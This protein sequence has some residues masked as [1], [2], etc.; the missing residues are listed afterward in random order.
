MVVVIRAAP[1]VDAQ[2]LGFLQPISSFLFCFVF[3]GGGGGCLRN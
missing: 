3:F 1:G 2:Q